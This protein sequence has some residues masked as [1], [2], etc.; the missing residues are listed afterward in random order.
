VGAWPWRL[1]AAPRSGESVVFVEIAEEAVARGLVE[2]T[3]GLLGD[4]LREPSRG[5]ARGQDPLDGA[6]LEGAEVLRVSVAPRGVR[7][8]TRT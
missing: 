8:R 6:A 1:L 3:D 4:V 2:A 5:G 7:V